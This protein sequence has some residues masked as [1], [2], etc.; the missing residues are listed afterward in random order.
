ML[1]GRVIRPDGGGAVPERVDE[2][3]AK[4]IPGYVRTVVKGNFVGVVAETEWGAMRAASTLKVHWSAPAAPFPADAFDHMRKATPKASRDL[5]KQGDAAGALQG[6]TRNVTASYEWPFQ[7]HA[8][9]G[10]GCA[11][12]DVHADGVTTVWSGAQ[13]PHALQKGLAQLLGV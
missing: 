10:P 8:T 7:A 4:A 3:A 9:M 6:A 11:V 2:T 1:H 12:A 13:K 5:M